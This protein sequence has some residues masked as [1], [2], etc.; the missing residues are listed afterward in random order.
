MTLTKSDWKLLI[1]Y[2]IFLLIG[3]YGLYS[4]EFI[5]VSQTLE[6]TFKWCGIP[7]L[8]LAAYYGYRSS[9]AVKTKNALWQRI[10]QFLFITFIMSMICFISFQGLLTLLNSKV[11]SQKDY[12]LRGKIIKLHYPKNKKILNKYG[13]EIKRELENDIIQ[14]DVPT[15]EYMENQIFKKKMVIGSLGFIYS[16]D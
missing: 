5:A 16:K 9:F 3:V 13:I 10:L 15:N 4:V 11:G 7:I 6:K 14:L 12:V 8:I 1:P 2:G